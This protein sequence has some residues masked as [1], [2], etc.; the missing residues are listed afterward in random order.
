M[1]PL[2][3]YLWRNGYA[4]TI[5]KAVITIVVNLIEVVLTALVETKADALAPT[6]VD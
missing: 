5:G 2:T 4:M 1:I 6:F 3:K